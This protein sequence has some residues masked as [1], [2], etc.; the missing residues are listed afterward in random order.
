MPLHCVM[1]IDTG[2]LF[3]WPFLVQYQN[4]KRLTSQPEALSNEGFH[5]N[6]GKV[7]L[8]A[9]FLSI[10]NMGRRAVKKLPCILIQCSSW[11]C[12]SICIIRLLALTGL[13]E[14]KT[15]LCSMPASMIRSFMRTWQT[16]RI[17]FWRSCKRKYDFREPFAAAL[18]GGNLKRGDIFCF[19]TPLHCWSICHAP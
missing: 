6:A 13:Q 7:G 1:I 8:L 17:N 4:E 2:W 10:L 19:H 9:F 3:N 5:G 12:S 14:E 15:N 11:E 16:H 18:L